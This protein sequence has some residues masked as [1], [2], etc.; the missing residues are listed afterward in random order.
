MTNNDNLPLL[1]AEKA[2]S[3]A[4]SMSATQQEEEATTN[5]DELL[6]KAAEVLLEVRIIT[7]SVSVCGGESR[8]SS[9]LRDASLRVEFR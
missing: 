2:K 9:T 4:S 1:R 8:E 7:L 3:S 6:T 5:Y